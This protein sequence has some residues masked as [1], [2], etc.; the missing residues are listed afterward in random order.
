MK[1]GLHGRISNTPARVVNHSEA[2]ITMSITEISA[3]VR[4][5]RV[6]ENLVMRRYL[7]NI[8]PH[9]D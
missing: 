7:A 4:Q 3:E 8:E 9:P 1:S 2:W 5:A 6:R